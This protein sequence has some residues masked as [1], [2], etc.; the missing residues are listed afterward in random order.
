MRG[1]LNGETARLRRAEDTTRIDAKLAVR[2]GV[3][4]AVTHQAAS[5]DELTILIDRGHCVPSRQRGELRAAAIEERVR[6]DHQRA[7]PELGQCCKC[8]IEFA[9]RLRVQEL[10]P[11]PKPVCHYLEG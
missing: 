7:G 11:Q 6:S 8:P 2:I 5:R 1:L 4:G 3:A 9:V 10:Q